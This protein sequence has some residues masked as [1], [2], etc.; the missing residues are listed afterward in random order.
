MSSGDGSRIA[1]I[2]LRNIVPNKGLFVPG[3][4]EW[5]AAKFFSSFYI[6]SPLFRYSPEMSGKRIS[7]SS[8]VIN[9]KPYSCL[10]FSFLRQFFLFKMDYSSSNNITS[11]YFY[12]EKK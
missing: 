11:F 3:M 8:V 4:T 7:R 2:I 10:K 1:N 9:I 6:F 12:L 5:P